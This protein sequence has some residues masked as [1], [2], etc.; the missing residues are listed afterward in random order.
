MSEDLKAMFRRLRK[1]DLA[2]YGNLG[3]TA[4][5]GSGGGGGNSPVAA[6]TTAPELSSAVVPSAGTTLGLTYNENLLASGDGVPDIADYSISSGGTAVTIS[7]V[8]VSGA[9]VTLNLA[10]TITSGETLSFNYTAGASGRVQDAS[11]NIASNL[12][13]QAVTN[14][15]ADVQAPSLSGATD[16]K[17]GSSTANLKVVSDETNGTTYYVVTKSAT[18]PSAAQVKSGLDDGG[19]AA[20]KTG[21]ISASTT[22]SWG[23]T[24]LSASTTFYAHFMQEDVATNQSS[25]ASGDGFITDAEGGGDVTAPVLS[26]PTAVGGTTS[27]TGTLTV[28]TDEGNGFLYWVVTTSSTSPSAAQ[29]KAGQDD[30]G[31]T[32]SDSGSSAVSGTGV[33]TLTDA[34]T[35][36]AGDFPYYAHF[37]HEDTATNQSTVVSTSTPFDSQWAVVELL[38][39]NEEGANGGGTFTDQSVNGA[40]VSKSG[41][42]T[43]SNT[44]T[45]GAAWDTAMVV[46]S[47]N[48]NVPDHATLELGGS[49]NDFCIEI[50]ARSG[51]AGTGFICGKTNAAGN[52]LSWEIL[53]VSGGG[54][55]L[56]VSANGT[57][58][59]MINAGSLKAS[60]STNTWYHIVVSRTGTTWNGYVDGTRNYTATVA[61]TIA[62]TATVVSIGGRDTSAGLP[63]N[64]RV[65]SFRLTSGAARYTGATLTVPTAPYP[66][67]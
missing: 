10:R 25:V 17:T 44:T 29:V 26:S 19:I 13:S 50:W 65:A 12:S 16:T 45:P 14:N 4:Q 43:W 37:M 21:S 24:S 34:A 64:G 2:Y 7:A 38:L 56:Y 47:Q 57:S 55:N 46:N 39:L 59:N 63:L 8:S 53:F 11:N 15:A 33:Q 66:T 27:G 3:A 61:G 18:P 62:D 60:W 1:K 22:L 58:N 52:V 49:S 51:V 36:L 48:I 41:T 5:G 67:A 32:A 31:A 35:G 30:L 20:V 6:D 28:S 54:I 9:I 40:T 23:V 42:P